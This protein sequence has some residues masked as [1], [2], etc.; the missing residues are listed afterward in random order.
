MYDQD[1]SGDSDRL[2][3]LVP[4]FLRLV[5]PPLVDLRDGVTR[6]VNRSAP[7]P[8]AVH[9]SNRGGMKEVSSATARASGPDWSV[10]VPPAATS[11][12]RPLPGQVNASRSRIASGTNA[13]AIA[14]MQPMAA[15][16]TTPNARRDSFMA[17][18]MPKPH[19]PVIVPTP[20]SGPPRVAQGQQPSPRRSAWSVRRNAIPDRSGSHD[21]RT[22][23][24]ASGSASQSGDR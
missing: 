11:A 4:P 1:P 13:T 6:S 2:R 19:A 22:R 14:A 9:A 16:T 21:E 5:K 15:T 18:T 3:R 8:G 10:A 17:I 23:P 24:G 20:Q 12:K 7:T